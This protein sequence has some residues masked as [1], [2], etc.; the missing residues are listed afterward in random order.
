[1]TRQLS[2]PVVLIVLTGCM[3]TEN[4]MPEGA[5][6]VP[7][8]DKPVLNNIDVSPPPPFELGFEA[9]DLKL[10]EFA[11]FH[12]S[13]ADAGE[14]VVFLRGYGIGTDCPSGFAPLC[15]DILGPQ[16]MLSLIH[17]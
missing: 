4:Q 13:G 11:G 15:T 16:L 5:F 6:I 3:P 2:L 8:A 10:G 1:M 17:I 14:N 7:S 12:A 9:D